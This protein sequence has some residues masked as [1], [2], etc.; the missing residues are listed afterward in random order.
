[1]S[2]KFARK[3]LSRRTMLRGLLGGAAVAVALPPLEAMLDAHGEALANG[4]PLPTRFISWFFGNGVHLNR[5]EPEEIGPSWS[6]SEELAP[7][8]N[9][10]DYVSVLTGLRNRCEELITHHEGMTAFSGYTMAEAS[11][12]ELFSKAGGPT[13]D[14]IIADCVGQHSIIDSV[15]IGISKRPSVMDGG[16]TMH[17]LSHRGTNL[18]L[19]PETNPQKVWQTLF[20]NFVPRP[21]DRALRQSILDAVADD[22]RRLKGELGT[23]DRQ[24]L[25]AHLESVAALQAKVAAA[26]P[27]CEIPGMPSETN[28]DVGGR[29]PLI[30]V[31][32]AMNSLLAYAF[33]CDITRVASVMFLPGAGETVFTDLGQVNSHHDNT[34][35]YPTALEPV[36]EAVVYTMQRFADLLERLMATE[37]ID[38]TNLLDSSIVYCSSDCAEGWSHSVERQPVILAGHGRQ[39]LIHPG[40]HYQAAP[41]PGAAGNISDVLLS[42]LKAFEPTATEIGA[43]DPRSTTPLMAITGPNWAG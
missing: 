11:F 32:D 8:V 24:R 10:K 22:A 7:L 17:A 27:A 16:T 6:L 34:H 9:V 31:N 42:V 5:F 19:Y 12:D 20:G 29:E 33:Q 26:P 14:Q 15:Q 37:E 3:H 21:D 40:I 36:H 18:P 43:G 4:D 23:H 1:M 30:A 28:M 13:L 39:K 35:D 25:D 2:G 41:R 38:G